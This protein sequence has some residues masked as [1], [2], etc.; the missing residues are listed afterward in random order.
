MDIPRLPDWIVS[1]SHLLALAAAP[2][3]LAAASSHIAGYEAVP[4][5]YAPLNKM[6]M[7]IQINGHPAN[8]LVDTGAEHT[9][10]DTEAAQLCA[11]AANQFG[12]RR[13]I[14]YERIN[15][16]LC[17]IAFVRNLTVGAMNIGN[18]Q[19]ALVDSSARGGLIT[20]ANA[21]ARVD[22]ILGA[23]ILV[24][25]RA[26]INTRTK[27]VFFKTAASVPLQLSAAVSSEKFTTV[28]LRHEENG[29]FTVSCSINGQQRRV[30]VD[31]G[32]FVTTL[33]ERLLRSLGIALQPAHV[34][35]HFSDGISR[36]Y[37]MGQV[38]DFT[39]GGFRVRPE[40]IAAAPLPKLGPERDAPIDGI[41]GMDILY[42]CHA[43]IDFGSMNLFLK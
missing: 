17:P 2:V 14:G 25:H 16:Q 31:T 42:D 40:K 9:T 35:G 32:A 11:V 8:L 21:T 12:G 1:L 38:N 39:I 30:F 33:N 28:P 27:L 6:I 3:C 13:Y 22:G 10:L 23:D 29:G 41:V 7:P 26:V 36:H 20:R 4:V 19:V 37:S 24:A 5:R 34:T 15:G 18:I 43:I